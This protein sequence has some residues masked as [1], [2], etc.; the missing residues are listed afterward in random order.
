MFVCCAYMYV[1][2]FDSRLAGWMDGWMRTYTIGMRFFCVNYISAK[3]YSFVYLAIYVS[4]ILRMPLCL[5][6][7]FVELCT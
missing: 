7:F 3:V 5:R 6:L 4:M 1:W 2:V